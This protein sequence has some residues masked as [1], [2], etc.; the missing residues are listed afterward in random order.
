M[1]FIG[2]ECY[3]NENSLG[4]TCWLGLGFRRFSWSTVEGYTCLVSFCGVRQEPCPHSLHFQDG[5]RCNATDG[6]THLLLTCLA[7]LVLKEAC[8]QK[9]WDGYQEFYSFSFRHKTT[10]SDVYKVNLDSGYI[11]NVRFTKRTSNSQWR[12]VSPFLATP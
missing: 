5:R 8:N 4:E 12:E 3:G 7:L 2:C 1:Q 9:P 6:C 11:Q 10:P